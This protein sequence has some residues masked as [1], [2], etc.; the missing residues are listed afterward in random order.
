MNHKKRIIVS[1]SICIPLILLTFT[2]YY[3]QQIS[4]FAPP[5][6]ITALLILDIWVIGKIIIT[7]VTIIK[8]RRT[9]SFNLILPTLI[10]LST[11]IIIYINPSFLHAS[12]YQPKIVYR[13]CYEGTV[14][15][16]IIRFRES[17]DFEYLHS[18]FM[19]ITTFKKGK[20]EQSGDTLL[21]KYE[22]E[23]PQ[24]VG[25]KLILT[26]DK[27]IKVVDDSLVS[28]RAGFYRGY[29]KGLN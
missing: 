24:F 15:T 6:G 3:W 8:K 18:G 27:F 25:D 11:F 7:L 23:I 5:L 26:E 29:C 10:Y 4:E 14:N 13:G 19:A 22:D 20:W 12:Y 9:L 16:G 1:L 21:I 2:E 17:G 28:D